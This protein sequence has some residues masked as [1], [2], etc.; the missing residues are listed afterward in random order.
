MTK[1]VRTEDT[2]NGRYDLVVRATDQGVPG[3]LYSDVKVFIDVGSI[4]NMKPKFSQPNY[5]I[6][7]KENAEAG[8]EIIALV[9]NDPDGDDNGL[10]FSIHSGSKDNFVIEPRS[11]VISVAGD[12][13]LSI[14][15]NGELYDMEVKVTDDG[16]PYKQTSFTNVQISVQDVNNIPPKFTEESYTEYVVENEPKGHVVLTVLAQ[17]PDRNADLEYDIVEPIYARDK[18]G[19]KLENIAAYNYKDAFVIDP[20]NGKISINE[21]LSYSSAAVIILTVQVADKNAETERQ[22]DTAEVT[23]YIKAFNADNPVFPSPWT[24]SDPTITVNISENIPPGKAIFKLAAKD[25][26]TGQDIQNY[27]KLDKGRVLEESIQISPFGDV[28]SNQMLDFEQVRAVKF[29][30]AAIA[31]DIGQ[32][33]V[34]EAEVILQLIDVNDNAPVFDQGSYQVDISE[35]VLPLTSVVT[36]HAADADTGDFGKV[37]Y[38]IQGE[39]SNEFMIGKTTGMIQVK[40]GSLGR[41]N[42]DREWIDSYNLRVIARDMPGGGSDQ[43]TSTVVVKVNLLDVN[44]SPPR[45]PSRGTLLWSL[46]T[47]LLAPLWPRCPPRILTSTMLSPMTSPAQVKSITC[48]ELTRTMGKSTPMTS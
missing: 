40:K 12:A 42:L 31:G 43:K 45:F 14:E 44:D 39:G 6:S 9:A 24:P 37:T 17:D 29:S 47:L 13:D 8:S 38:D 48:I 25:P 30:V 28:I 1:P 34:S 4:R 16:D 33:R 46:K 5:Q 23:L 7:I 11:G 10:R 19:T 2:E 18:S 15:Q 3:T 26:L 36:V 35:D 32:E 20:R 27:Q 21:K 41:S 22:I